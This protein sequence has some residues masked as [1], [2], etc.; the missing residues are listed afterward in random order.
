MSIERIL[1]EVPV[2]DVVRVRQSFPR[3]VVED[4]AAELRTRLRESGMLRAL[5]RDDTVALGVGSRGISQLP[6][7]VRTLVAEIEVL[8]AKPFIVPSMGSHGGANSAGQVEVLQ[9]L[10]VSEASVGAPIR[11]TMDVLEIGRT[12]AGLPAYLDAYAHEANAIV[13]LNAVK[14]HVAFRGAFES[15]LLK[16]IAIGL[17]KQRGADVC[18]DLGFGHMAENVQAIARV[19]LSAANVLGGVGVLENA[20]GETCQV[21]AVPGHAIE[22][23]EPALLERAR[24]LAPRLH[25]G[26]LDVLVVDQI[27]KDIS[28][29]GFDTNVIGR[30]HTPYASGGPVIG[31]IAVLDLSERSG[32]NAHGIGLADFTTRRAFEK[33]SFERTYPNSLTSTQPA[34]AKIPMVLESDLLAIRAAIKTSNLPEKRHVRLARVRNTKE[35]GV[36]EV[37]TSLL[38]EVALHPHLQAEGQ[39]SPLPF[40]DAGQLF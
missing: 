38:E 26:R 28:G 9:S 11:A 36:I 23:E 21:A 19:T 25:F 22:A 8:G 35:L 37:S 32:G 14:P 4:V 5:R 20:Y 2:P 7:L 29:T 30:Y 33:L 27:G 12:P 16:M 17:G 6:L 3:P 31:R 15:G 24:E 34:T 18:H 1:S 13:V 40:D 10:G 39:P